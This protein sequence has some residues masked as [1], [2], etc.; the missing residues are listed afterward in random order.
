M[1]VADHQTAGRGRLGR[2]WTAPPRASLLMSILL[3]P[4]L[5]PDRLHL[6]TAAR[7]SPGRRGSSRWPAGSG[8]SE[9]AERPGPSTIDQSRRRSWPRPSGYR[10]RRGASGSTCD[11]ASELPGEPARRGGGQPRRWQRRRPRRTCSTHRL[12]A[13]HDDLTRRPAVARK[14]LPPEGAPRFG[15]H[16]A[17]LLTSSARGHSRRRDR[18]RP[19]PRRC[20]R[21]P[22]PASRL[23][24]RR[25]RPP[26]PLHIHLP[27]P[28][29]PGAISARYAPGSA[30]GR[31][32]APG[33]ATKGRRPVRTGR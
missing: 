23:H 21:L 11:L 33:A 31:E 6:V 13:L 27:C 7:P 28:G 12:D 26:L 5:A 22:P 1:A 20:R 29:R 18:R 30:A 14:A 2:V 15:R 4:D 19:P 10:R 17:S 25:R 8:G 32:R 24:R 3:R 16:G 9:V